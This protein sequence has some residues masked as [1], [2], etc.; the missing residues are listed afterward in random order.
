MARGDELIQ[1]L[2]RPVAVDDRAV[3]ERRAN[4]RQP[5]DRGRRAVTPVSGKRCEKNKNKQ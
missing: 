3:D 1:F 2:D 4:K 5:T